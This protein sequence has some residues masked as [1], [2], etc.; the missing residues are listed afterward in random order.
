M[1]GP[2]GVKVP[3]GILVGK[4]D[5]VSDGIHCKMD[6]I[7]KIQSIGRRFSVPWESKGVYLHSTDIYSP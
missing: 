2:A 7:K 5:W 3:D 1:Q 6:M 4:G